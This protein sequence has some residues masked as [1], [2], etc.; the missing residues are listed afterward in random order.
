MRMRLI[1]TWSLFII[2]V[3]HFGAVLAGAGEVAPARPHEPVTRRLIAMVEGDRELSGLLARSIE[4]AREVNPDQATNPVQSVE[5]Y[6]AFV[7]W[8]AKAMPWSIVPGLPHSRL[9]D[10]I[11]QGL[12]YFYFLVDQPLPELKD[13]G[14]VRESLQYHEPFRTWLTDFAGEWGAFLSQAGS[15]SEEALQRAKDDERFGLGKGWFEGPSHWK[16][17][18]DFFSRRLKSPD[19]RPIASPDDFSVVSSPADSTPQGVWRIDGESVVVSAGGVPLKSGRVS[20]VAALLG[21]DSAYRDAF[22]NG[23]MTFTYLD[24]YDYHRC[25]FPVSGTIREV[26]VIRGS[27]V[28]GGVITWSAEARRYLFEG[29]SPTWQF[30][31]TRGRVVVETEKHG[32]VALLPVGMCQMSSVNFEEAVKPGGRVSKGD[33]LGYYLFGGSG[34]VMIFQE[35]AGF[36]LTV[37]RGSDN[38]YSH[39]LMGEEYGRL[40]TK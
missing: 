35:K 2:A 13:K 39:V 28:S 17:F 14:Y 25:H 22:A 10:Q 1:R 12:A 32:L 18:N 40:A 34:F 11:D 20:S 33:R 5:E 19:Q 29:S 15:W 6:Y 36:T 26:G 24:E 30:L 27:A 21:E 9:Y 38:C 7:D 16:T 8:A 31:E 3:C 23:V 37:K 4:M